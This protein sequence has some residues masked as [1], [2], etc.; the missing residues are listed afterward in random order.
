MLAC[1]CSSE[2]LGI[3]VHHCLQVTTGI[4]TV[5]MRRRSVKSCN[6]DIGSGEGFNSFDVLSFC[7]ST[8]I[9]I[10]ARER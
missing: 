3:G 9:Y 5:D 1:N 10:L 8:C 4:E 7:A 6:D 2:V